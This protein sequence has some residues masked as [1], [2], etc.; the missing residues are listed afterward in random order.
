[1]SDETIRIEINGES[2][3]T[4]R[5]AMIIEAAD[6]AGIRIPRFCYHHKLSV[7]ANCRMC[8]VEVERAPKALPA[9]ATP[10][11]DGMKIYTESPKAV[12]GQKA[13][14]E[15]LLINHPLDCP[16]CDQGGECELQ[17][18]AMGYGSSVSQF[19]ERKRSVRDQN[20]GPLVQMEMTRCIHCTRCVRF[21]D[22]IA[23]LREL[24][25]IGRGEFMEI[26]T[27]IEHELVSELSGNVIDLCPVGA[28][29]AKPSRYR[30]RAWEMVQHSG[31]A[32]HDA[33]GSNVSIHTLRNEVVRVVPRDNES[34]NECWI[35]D[36]DRFA[37]LGLQADDRLAEPMVRDR[38]GLLR[39]VSWARALEESAN[40]LKGTLERHGPEQIG[41]LVS[42][43]VSLEELYLLQKLM[44]GMGV[45]NIDH[46]LRQTD[47]RDQ[48]EAP[49][50]PWLGQSIESLGSL[51]AALMIGADVRMEAPIIG[52]RI[53]KAAMAGGRMMFINPR[54]FDFRFPVST[55]I[56]TRP[57]EMIVHLGYVAVALSN[58]SKTSLP[59]SFAAVTDGAEPDEDHQAIAGRLLDAESATVLLGN[60]ALRHPMLRELRLLAAWI[61][62]TAG[63]RFGYVAEGGNAA[64]AWLAGA[65]PHRLPGAEVDSD[66][67]LDVA[68]MLNEP[69][70]GYVLFGVEADLDCAAGDGAV[71]ALRSADWV[72]SLSPFLGGSMRDVVDL[73]LP[74][75]GF[76]ES[77]GTWVNAEGRWQTVQGA[78][79][80][81]GAARPGWKVL[82]VLGNEL[83]LPGFDQTSVGEVSDEMFELCRAVE[84]SSDLRIGARLE[85]PE[86][87]G[88]LERGGDV[89]IYSVDALVRRSQ[90]LQRTPVAGRSV[91]HVHPETAARLGVD[92]GGTIE[93]Q[94]GGSTALLPLAVDATIP[95]GC[96]WIPS[97]LG[98]TNALGVPNGSI[99][100]GAAV[101]PAA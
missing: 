34:I 4:R 70:K 62:R 88:E 8:L 49:P 78:M 73:A 29:T 54:D 76:A 12:A 41:V 26:G 67:G 10:V 16:I 44:R 31:I 57:S 92:D 85:V 36:R 35:S 64:G 32:P 56:V 79:A 93:V 43:S 51:E 38:D 13:T 42:P 65:V 33:A 61:A 60:I 55:K 81:P 47:F 1:M 40:R 72:L 101:E 99:I 50:F 17:D 89:P 86:S 30:G 90:P 69:R 96:V 9:C 7:A 2:L 28:L 68:R 82:R 11:M 52:H 100:V 58:I 74:I 87:S 46:R 5:G 21:G 84:P 97:A 98:E 39:A 19:A 48:R 95:E 80:P 6:A 77:G 94:Q 15:F 20:I 71:A 24:G 75:G 22:E 18:V 63:V 23:G 37:Y 91:A 83:A 45:H 27:F 66:P 53:R 14:M 3:E 59:K 25:A